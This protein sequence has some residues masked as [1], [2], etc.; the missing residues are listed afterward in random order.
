MEFNSRNIEPTPTSQPA[1]G[2][3]IVLGVAALIVVAAVGYIL[4][5]KKSADPYAKLKNDPQA[6]NAKVQEVLAA[7]S[8]LTQVP[9]GETPSLAVVTDE[10]ALSQSN[11]FFKDVKNDDY[12]LFFSKAA[13]VYRPST[14]AIV[15][16][17][18]IVFQGQVAGA[19]QATT[20]PQVDPA[21]IDILNGTG[22]SGVAADYKTKLEAAIPAYKVVKTGSPNGNFPTSKLY[23]LTGKNVSL[24]EAAMGVKAETELPSGEAAT[25]ADIVIIL[26]E[27]YKA[28]PT[29]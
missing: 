28:A 2:K 23:N 14:D 3:K 17:G 21:N 11:V 29:Q 6:A 24:L 7:V 12:V 9:Q 8:K 25:T 1:A 20:T 5:S 10:K 27:D 16:A 4:V 19:E 15:I 22:Q 26:G 13:V 18:P